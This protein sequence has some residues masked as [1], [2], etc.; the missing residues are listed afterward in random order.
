V[1]PKLS[2][3]PPFEKGPKGLALRS[4]NSIFL[5]LYFSHKLFLNLRVLAPPFPKVEKVD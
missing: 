1:E 3:Y 5:L 4:Q 2:I